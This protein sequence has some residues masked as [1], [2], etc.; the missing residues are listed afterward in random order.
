MDMDMESWNDH[1]M[2]AWIPQHFVSWLLAFGCLVF[3]MLLN[4]LGRS[5]AMFWTSGD[6]LVS[7]VDG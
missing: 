7:G 2:I 3:C 5:Q 1:G 4:L 6:S